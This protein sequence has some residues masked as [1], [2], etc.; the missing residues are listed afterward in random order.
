MIPAVAPSKEHGFSLVELSVVMIIISFVTAMGVMVGIG[1]IEGAKVTQTQRK[2]AAI[3]QALLAYRR[4]NDRLPCP[5]DISL[6][7][8]NTSFGSESVNVGGG[9]CVATALAGGGNNAVGGAIPV[10]TLGL[11]MEFAYDGWG[12]RFYY[13]VDKRI[14]ET[15]G[16]FSDPLYSLTAVPGIGD[17]T[18]RDASGVSRTDKAVYALVS[19]GSNKHGGVIGTAARISTGS[20]NVD[21]LQNCN[22]TNTAAAGVI[23]N[24]F[25]QKEATV[26]PASSSDKFDDIV[27]YKVRAQLVNYDE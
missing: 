6:T 15:G 2:I 12:E 25:V 17:I 14:A 20:T 27:S 4:V 23:D 18:V 22:C 5:A 26:N 16:T 24:I 11:P 21:E 19:Y 10:V 8:S 3:E 1:Q 9:V 13:A 7:D